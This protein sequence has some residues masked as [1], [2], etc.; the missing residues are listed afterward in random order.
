MM[1]FLYPDLVAQ[2]ISPARRNLVLTQLRE[3]H[4]T[5]TISTGDPDYV[6]LTFQWMAA[7]TQRW[8]DK[9][10]I[11]KTSRDGLLAEIAGALTGYS[12]NERLTARIKMTQYPSDRGLL[13]NSKRARD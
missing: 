1:A 5:G 7:T 6:A 4:E 11:K 9:G 13:E 12:R 2:N 3:F 8:V 10:L